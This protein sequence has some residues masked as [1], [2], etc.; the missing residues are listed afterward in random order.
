[1][2]RVRSH[3]KIKTVDVFHPA[4][5][6]GEG[7]GGDAL[8]PEPRGPLLDETGLPRKL[9]RLMQRK[10]RAED[11]GAEEQAGGRRR[12]RRP[13]G[14]AKGA[15]PAPL[16]GETPTDY[17][18]RLEA[19]A[20]T[21]MRERTASARRVR[22]GRRVHLAARKQKQKERQRRHRPA[23]TATPTPTT[24]AAAAAAAAGPV[25][26]GEVA[27]DIPHLTARPRGVSKLRRP[28]PTATATAPTATALGGDKGDP[29]ARRILE[30][31]RARVIAHYRQLK[32]ARLL[33]P[34]QH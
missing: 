15:L 4:R 2:G 10:S 7:E 8:P 12:D 24:T 31:E 1:M 16:L 27:K 14:G 25:R 28:A 34:P 9:Q 17:H 11:A 6:R 19:A 13:G 33:L 20:A 5:G 3:K 22:E 18:R 21:L 32:L 26:F 29:A 23:P 30:T